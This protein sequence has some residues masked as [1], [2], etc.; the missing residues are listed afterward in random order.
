MEALALGPVP[1]IPRSHLP[2]QQPSLL[3]SPGI[4]LPTL[5]L[6]LFLCYFKLFENLLVIRAQSIK[7]ID[8]LEQ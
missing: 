4:Y 3:S 2:R 7:L 1:E 5:V 6:I 8:I